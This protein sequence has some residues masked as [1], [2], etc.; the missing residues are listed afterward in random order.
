MR[1]N[2]SVEAE[3]RALAGELV[4]ERMPSGENPCRRDRPCRC[5][6]L[7]DSSSAALA[8]VVEK[9]PTKSRPNRRRSSPSGV[10]VLVRRQA[11]MP[12]T[13]TWAEVQA[14]RR[15]TIHRSVLAWK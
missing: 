10:L 3:Q 1:S 15:K 14:L 2:L 4:P 5:S 8:A 13:L 7:A 9:L 11:E 12:E 6:L